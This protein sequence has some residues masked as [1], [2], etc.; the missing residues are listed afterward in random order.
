[1][2]RIMARVCGQMPTPSGGATRIPMPISRIHSGRIAAMTRNS[3]R[4]RTPPVTELSQRGG[5][6]THAQAVNIATGMQAA[7]LRLLA[8]KNPG[9]TSRLSSDTARRLVPSISIPMAP[10]I[11]LSSMNTT[12]AR[13]MASSDF[14]HRYRGARQK[15]K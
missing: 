4:Q 5:C 1:M 6:C 13:R 10:N 2:P 11:P 8:M 15:A 12:P 14:H 7:R 3:Q 9:P